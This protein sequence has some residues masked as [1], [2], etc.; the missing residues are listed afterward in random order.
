[1]EPKDPIDPADSFYQQLDSEDLLKTH[2]KELFDNV[3]EMLAECPDGKFAGVLGQPDSQEARAMRQALARMA[4]Q[5]DQEAGLIAVVPR[6]FVEP[7]LRKY[8]DPGI[9]EEQPWQRQRVFPIVVATKDGFRF[10]FHGLPGAA[11]ENEAG[12]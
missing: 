1:M 7:I 5:P 9:W 8:V 4:G 3:L 11:D 2:G 12:A 6:S 10:G